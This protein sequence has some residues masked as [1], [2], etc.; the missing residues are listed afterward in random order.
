MFQEVKGRAQLCGAEMPVLPASSCSP[1]TKLDREDSLSSS[2]RSTLDPPDFGRSRHHGSEA[3]AGTSDSAPRITRSITIKRHRQD[4]APA[5][6]H[7]PSSFSPST[8]SGIWSFAG[9]RQQQASPLVFDWYNP[10]TL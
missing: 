7:S 1:A 4:R 6:Q 9:T 2:P 5:A 8:S 3:A 10:L